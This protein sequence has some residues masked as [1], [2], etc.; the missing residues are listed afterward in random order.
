MLHVI[1]IFSQSGALDFFYNILGIV[2]F[3]AAL[4]VEISP[5]ERLLTRAHHSIKMLSAPDGAGPWVS[6][7]QGVEKVSDHGTKNLDKRRNSEG[8]L[9]E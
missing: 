2:S 8:N 3:I 6:H 9:L 5:H 1:F 7:V 4:C